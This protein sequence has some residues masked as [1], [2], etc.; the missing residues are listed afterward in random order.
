MASDN[1]N[2]VLGSLPDDIEKAG[3]IQLQVNCDRHL[4]RK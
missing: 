3:K 4:N 2:A 1:I